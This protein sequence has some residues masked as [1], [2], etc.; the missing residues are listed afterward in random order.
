M[1]TLIEKGR[2]RISSIIPVEGSF[3]ERGA[4]GI[5]SGIISSMSGQLSLDSYGRKYSREQLGQAHSLCFEVSGVDWLMGSVLGAC[6]SMD[7][8]PVWEDSSVAGNFVRDFRV[9]T[10][11]IS[12]DSLGSFVFPSEFSRSLWHSEDRDSWTCR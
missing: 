3:D 10:V 4:P 2:R 1:E 11:L 9:R 5:R 8:N 12:I 6:R 7:G